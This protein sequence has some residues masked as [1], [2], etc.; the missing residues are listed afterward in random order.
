MILLTRPQMLKVDRCL[1]DGVASDDYQQAT[2]QAIRI[3]AE[4]VGATL[5]AEGLE[6]EADAAMLRELGVEFAQGYLFSWPR[7]A[8]ELVAMLP[9]APFALPVPRLP[10][11]AAAC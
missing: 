5:V 9:N 10:E 1:I 8:D 2:L 7:L 6:R 4:K 11:L 3:L